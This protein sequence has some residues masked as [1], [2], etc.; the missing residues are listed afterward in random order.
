MLSF[1]LYLQMQ[2]MYGRPVDGRSQRVHGVREG[3]QI[4]VYQGTENVMHTQVTK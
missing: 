3:H 1:C 2:M 4:Y